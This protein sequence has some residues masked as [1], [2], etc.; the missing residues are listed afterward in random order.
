MVFILLICAF[1]LS[2]KSES[3]SI[4]SSWI[5]ASAWMEILP[6]IFLIGVISRQDQLYALVHRPLS[7]VVKFVNSRIPAVRR[8]R[9]GLMRSAFTKTEMIDSIRIVP[10]CIPD[11]CC[12][13]SIILKLLRLMGWLIISPASERRHSF[14][15]SSPLGIWGGENSAV[16]GG[17]TVANVGSAS[18]SCGLRSKVI[19]WGTAAPTFSYSFHYLS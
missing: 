16:W 18:Q 17:E 8:D 11:C 7:L 6:T 12:S 1:R 15:P 13:M 9:T 2:L 19:K 3:I 4:S 5:L 10:L 14:P